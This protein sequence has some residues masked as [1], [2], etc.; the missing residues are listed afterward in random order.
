M[1]TE[2]SS[3]AIL[4]IIGSRIKET[5]IKQSKTQAE[6]AVAAGVAPLTVANI[7]N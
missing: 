5:R 7:E 4:A 6:L 3:P 2:M 1:W